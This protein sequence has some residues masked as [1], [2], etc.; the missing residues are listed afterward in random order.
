ML[1]LSRTDTFALN[2]FKNVIPL[3]AVS[4]TVIRMK[5][6]KLN[7]LLPVTQGGS[8]QLKKSENEKLV[9]F[10]RYSKQNCQFECT[11]R[12]TLETLGCIPRAEPMQIDKAQNGRFTNDSITFLG[13]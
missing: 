11:L 7:Q 6:P 9:Y 10:N 2:D 13:L 4:T 1:I 8:C 3:S 12:A 5:P